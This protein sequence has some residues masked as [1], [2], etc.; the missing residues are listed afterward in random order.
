MSRPPVAVG[1]PA[2]EVRLPLEDQAALGLDRLQCRQAR[3]GAIGQRLVG[4]RPEV[5]GGLQLRRVGREEEQMDAVW[6][7][8]RLAGVPAGTIEHQEDALGRSR[9]HLPGKGG[10]H[11]TE[12]Q[13]RHR[14]EQPPDRRTGGGANKATDV[15]PLIALLD[16]GNRALPFRCPHPADQRQQANAVLVGGPDFD[17][18]RGMLLLD[19]S[20]FVSQ[21]FF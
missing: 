10:Q 4:E 3:E 20:D 16:G 5:F 12:E 8:H 21:I 7:R 18:C 6:H 1:V 9:T 13:G 15:E 14:G 2:D 17:R 11:L 19:G